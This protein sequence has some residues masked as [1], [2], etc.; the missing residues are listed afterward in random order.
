M[1]SPK[2]KPILALHQEKFR[3]ILKHHPDH[4]YVF[5]DGS[6]ASSAFINKI[7]LKKALLMESSIFIAETCTIDLVLNIASELKEQT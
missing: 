6:K 1:N 4:L 2:Q 5:T 7:I 3:N